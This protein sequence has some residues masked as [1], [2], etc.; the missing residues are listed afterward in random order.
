MKNKTDK[1]VIKINDSETIIMKNCKYSACD[2]IA[3][4]LSQFND[5]YDIQYNDDAGNT[6]FINR[7]EWLVMKE[8]EKASLI[9]AMASIAID[10]GTNVTFYQ[11]GKT[12]TLNRVDNT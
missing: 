6:I 7:E 4:S 5:D 9:I 1:Y 3:V 12:V 8:N 11:N 10:N 2:A